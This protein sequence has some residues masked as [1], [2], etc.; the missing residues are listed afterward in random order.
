MT[1]R[2]PRL[3]LEREAQHR[4]GSRR[5][6][7][8]QH[9]KRSF[10]V[11]GSPGQLCPSVC[12]QRGLRESWSSWNGVGWGQEH[13]QEEGGLNQSTECQCKAPAQEASSHCPSGSTLPLLVCTRCAVRVTPGVHPQER[14]H[15]WMEENV[16]PTDGGKRD[17]QQGMQPCFQQLLGSPPW[18]LSPSAHPGHAALH[19]PWSWHSC[20]PPRLLHLLGWAVTR[21]HIQQS[22]V[23]ALL[24][25]AVRIPAALLLLPLTRQ[26]GQ[27]DPWECQP[28][29]SPLFPLCPRPQTPKTPMAN[30]I[31][32]LPLEPW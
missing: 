23:T 24:P 16:T 13:G 21:Q 12:L 15:S 32:K 3:H 22:L 27:P 11:P 25:Q 19:S 14:W 30:P 4:A 26:G 17:T 18:L 6:C 8:D 5:C 10:L 31:S 1:H 29:P 7:Q 2:A 9:S 28:I 20:S